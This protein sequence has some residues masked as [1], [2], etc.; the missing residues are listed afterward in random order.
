MQNTDNTDYTDD[1]NKLIEGV[2]S[3]KNIKHYEYQHFS[4]FRKI[5]SGAFG[6]VFRANWKNSGQYFALKSFFNVDNVAIRELVHEVKIYNISVY[7]I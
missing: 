7:L 5:G 3:K 4:D 1:S 6:I 2:I